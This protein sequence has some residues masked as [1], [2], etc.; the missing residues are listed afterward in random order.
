MTLNMA[1][2]GAKKKKKKKVNGICHCKN[3]VMKTD[4]TNNIKMQ[5]EMSLPGQYSAIGAK[6]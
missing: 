5:G 2:S 3:S 6:D 1:S 4:S